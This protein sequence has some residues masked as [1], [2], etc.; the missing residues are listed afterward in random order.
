[1]EVSLRLSVVL[2]L[3]RRSKVRWTTVPSLNPE[4]QG[5]S[6][7]QSSCVLH[8]VAV[9]LATRDEMLNGIHCSLLRDQNIHATR[10]R[11]EETHSSQRDKRG[12]TPPVKSRIKC[13]KHNVSLA[14]RKLGLL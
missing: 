1:M 14:G 4:P 9:T 12:I 11:Y 2:P 5:R 6:V 10:L 3:G 7:L 8:T 13:N